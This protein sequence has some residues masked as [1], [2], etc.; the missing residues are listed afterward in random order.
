MTTMRL[1]SSLILCATLAACGGGNDSG[2]PAPAAPVSPA[3]SASPAQPAPTPTPTLTLSSPTLRTIAGGSAIPLSATLSS[4]GA[5]RWRL[6]EGAPGTLDADS[7]AT[8]RYVPPAGALTAPATVTV[9]ASGDGASATLTLAVTPEPGAAGL[10]KVSWRPPETENEP[11][12][13]RPVDLAADLAGNAYVLLQNDA[14]PS[15]RGPPQ[16]VKIAPDGTLA[17]LI[18]AN[19]WFG[20]PD[21]AGNAQRL[22]WTSG[23]TVDRAGNLYFATSVFG[24]GIA[25][26]QQSSNGPLILKITPAGAVSVLAGYQGAQ[27]GA[28]VD[29]PAGKAQFLYPRI[30]GID[31]DGNLYLLDGDAF[32]LDAPVTP[33]K[34]TP[35]GVVTTLAA[36]PAGLKADM[37]GNT[38]RYDSAAKKLM[39]IAPD[40]SASVE[41][42]APYC[43]SFV[44]EPP[45]ACIDDLGVYAITP[46]G[47][48]SFLM[49]EVTGLHAVR[50]LVLPH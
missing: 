46:A 3:P 4:G 9:T 18:G 28:M 34:V 43:S 42:S 24:S 15:R 2:A 1:T 26:G 40:G 22:Y 38:Y 16:L 8:V 14:S 45:R 27:V 25:A 49:L 41:T 17:T 39:R 29:G 11:T 6:A 33:R 12:L 7:G 13:L 5:V 44:P 30:A 47:G 31:I 21:T 36:L 23:F 50:R 10:Y 48:T 37:K 35:D 32:P 19:T 20:Q